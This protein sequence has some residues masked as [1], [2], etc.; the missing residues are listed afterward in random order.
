MEMKNMTYSRLILSHNME[1]PTILTQSDWHNS[2]SSDF[3]NTEIFTS[4]KIFGTLRFADKEVS[5]KVLNQL[6]LL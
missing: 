1:W 6:L 3:G 5:L 2:T 4:I